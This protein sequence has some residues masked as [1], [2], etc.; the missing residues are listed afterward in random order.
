MRLKKKKNHL[1]HFSI[2]SSRGQANPTVSTQDVK[3][4]ESH[5]VVGIL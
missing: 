2:L 4:V 1:F 3:S 5:S